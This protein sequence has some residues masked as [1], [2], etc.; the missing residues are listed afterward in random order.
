MLEQLSYINHLGESITFGGNN[1]YV[2][3]NELHDFKW[4][5]IS[6][7]DRIAGFERR[8][9][10]K[11]F[12]VRIG[13]LSEQEGIAKRNKLFVVPEKD[14]LAMKPGKL[15]I[16][17][18]YLLC[19]VTSSTKTYYS[20]DG[21]FLSCD[22]VVTTDKPFWIREVEPEYTTSHGD[23]IMTNPSEFDSNFR[24]EFEG[25]VTN[26][27]VVIRGHSYK[28]NTTVPSGS[29][30]IID[31]LEERVYRHDTSSELDYNAFNDRDRGSYIFEK[32]PAGRSTITKPAS[33]TIK[34]YDERSEP[35]WVAPEDEQDYANWVYTLESHHVWEATEMYPDRSGLAFSI[36]NGHLI[37]QKE[38]MYSEDNYTENY[39]ALEEG[40]LAIYHD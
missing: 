11:S 22:I 39:G 18:F 1:A 40:R 27:E 13:A 34:I 19:Y 28:V 26:P 30:L 8:I 32:I 23:R 20:I 35:I 2:N 6:K 3:L 31:S 14:V 29:N 4:E 7:N 5:V 36:E 10:T 33:C 38:I 15:T 25:A 21:K 16:N 12:P 37:Q 17:G 9:H 24:M